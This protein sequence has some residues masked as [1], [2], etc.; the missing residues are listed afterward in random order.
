MIFYTVFLAFLSN[1]IS[2]DSSITHIDKIP[3]SNDNETNFTNH[4]YLIF[5]HRAEQCPHCITLGPMWNNA[6]EMGQGLATFSELNCITNEDICRKL[7]IYTVPSFVYYLNGNVSLYKGYRIPREI[8]NWVS[9]FVNTD[10]ISIVD[11]SNYSSM[12]NNEGS[13]NEKSQPVAIL[14]SDKKDIPKI[15]AA[16]NNVLNQY[17]RKKIVSF[18]F[19]ND[20]KLLQELKLSTFPGIYFSNNGKDFFEYTGKRITPRIVDFIRNH[21]GIN[22]DAKTE[23]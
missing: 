6:A 12:L 1:A 18:L 14:F 10:S 7:K 3:P 15:W 4:G 5:V 8:V 13:N 9:K 23:L 16:V 20:R 17:D 21:M 22:S 2:F 11:N 19:S